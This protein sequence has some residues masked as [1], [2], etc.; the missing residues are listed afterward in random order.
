MWWEYFIVNAAVCLVF[1]SVYIPMFFLVEALVRRGYLKPNIIVALA[2][3]ALI[4]IFAN[5]CY[6]GTIGLVI[7]AILQL[8]PGLA[9]FFSVAWVVC[10]YFKTPPPIQRPVV[11]VM[12]FE[13]MLT[14][15]YRPN[16]KKHGWCLHG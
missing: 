8:V 13:W 16:I 10:L 11:I 3:G 4:S 6:Q 9:M 14:I 5:A 1:T 12:P 2:I 7:T 15:R